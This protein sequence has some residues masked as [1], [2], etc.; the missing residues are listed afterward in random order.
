MPP[1]EISTN[2]HTYKRKFAC[3]KFSCAVC[4]PYIRIRFQAQVTQG[5]DGQCSFLTLTVREG[6]YTDTKMINRAWNLLLKRIQRKMRKLYCT[7]P[8]HEPECCRTEYVKILEQQ[9]NGQ[10]HIHAILK[11]PTQWYQVKR[12]KKWNRYKQANEFWLAQDDWLLKAWQEVIKDGKTTKVAIN[13]VVSEKGTISKELAKY[14]SKAR[15]K[16]TERRRWYSFSDGY[17]G[18]RPELKAIGST[19]VPSRYLWWGLIGQD[20]TEH[21]WELCIENK[22]S[23]SCNRSVIVWDFGTRNNNEHR[24]VFIN[25]DLMKVMIGGK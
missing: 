2:G 10:W 3:R 9:R 16:S 25:T 1:L 8:Y 13:P 11:R 23:C 4:G 24:N 7:R 19:L 5:L 21:N 18:C 15:S 14:L 22:D 6:V 12:E 20:S 17:R